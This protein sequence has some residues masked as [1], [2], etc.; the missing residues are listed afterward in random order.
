MATLKRLPIGS[1]KPAK[2]NPTNRGDSVG[3]KSHL[4][5]SMKRFG[6][7]QP[8]LVT[9]DR[10]L[11]DG[12]RRLATAIKL[13]WKE[14]P[15]LEV[16]GSA[17]E[18]YAE[19]NRLAIKINGNQALQIFLQEPKAIGEAAAK[20]IAAM[21][22]EIGPALTKRL[23]REG[24][25]AATWSLCKKVAKLADQDTPEVRLM[26]LK[27]MMNFRSMGTTRDALR[28]GASPGMIMAAAQKMK[29][30]RPTYA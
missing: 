10:H 7:I 29:N 20:K 5:P 11:V 28:K 26:L 2:Y 3:K 22:E 14:V 25:S 1:I 12:H 15:V 30:I 24:F 16:P 21:Q 13:G 9:K 18:L 23:A 17:A 6:M 4:G 8:L 19:V 27:W